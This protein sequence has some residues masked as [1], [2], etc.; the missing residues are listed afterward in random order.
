[1]R[2]TEITNGRMDR[3]GGLPRRWKLGV[4]VLTLAASMTLASCGGDGGGCQG[5]GGDT[6]GGAAG[7][8]TMASETTM[9]G[10]TTMMGGTTMGDTTMMGDTM[11]GGG[12]ITDVQA[13]LDA[14]RQDSQPLD[15]RLVQL[16]DAM[17]Q[18]V[19]GDV[20][21][22]V[23]PS[24]DQAVFVVLADEAAGAQVEQAVDINPGQ[25]LA[26]NGVMRPTPSAQEAQQ[27]LGLTLA[28]AEQLQNQQFYLF[29]EEVRIVG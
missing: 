20:S 12:A 25:T 4:G 15:G 7:G 26:I 8:T 14:Q 13:I 23:G 28:E 24:A 21:F 11:M 6:G 19:V 17:V 29:A 5:G 22:L 1:M 10:G 16:Q 2:G 3:V 9:G 18:E 27:A